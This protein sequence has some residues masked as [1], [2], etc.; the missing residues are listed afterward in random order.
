MSDVIG[1]GV[2]EVAADATGVAAGIDAAKR[3]IGT[4]ADAAKGASDKSAAS[5][6]RYIKKLEQQNAT[7]G[8]SAREVELY[9]LKLRGASEAQLA[10]ADAA[11]KNA[12][13]IKRAQAETADASAKAQ[14]AAERELELRDKLKNGMIAAAAATTAAIAATAAAAYASVNAVADQLAKYKDLSDKIGDSAAAIAALQTA[15]DLSGVSLDSVAGASIRLTSALS[16]TD[17]ESKSV[18]AGISALG[19][20]FAKFKEKSPVE[21]LDAVATA[22]AGF[23]DGAEK[24]A[25]AT[26]IFGKSGAEMIPFLNDLADGGE[27]QLKITDEQIAAADEFTKMQSRLK[28]EIADFTRQVGGTTLP[29]LLELI[30]DFKDAATGASGLDNASVGLA[31]NN[32]VQTFAE[33]GLTVLAHLAD[34]AYATGQAFLWLGNNIGTTAAG[35]AAVARLDMDAAKA[36]RAEQISFNDGFKL[37]L[38][39]ADK[40]GEKFAAM[41]AKADAYKDPR[42][43]GNPGSI[44]DQVSNSRPKINISGLAAPGKGGA[45]DKDTSAQDA[46][47]QL[48]I[49][50]DQI[51]AAGDALASAYGNAEKI[52]QAQKAANLVSDGEYYAAKLGFLRLNSAAQEAALQAEIDRLEREK[53]TGK[54]KL[55]NDKKIAE[56]REKLEKLRADTTTNI[57]VNTIQEAAAVA[58]LARSYD[59]AARA[60]ESYVNTIAR[61]SEREL[62]GIGQGAKARA[63]TDRR[64]QRDDQF[65]G[66]RDTLD[67]QLRAGQIGP[68]DYQKFL[69]IEQDAHDQALAADDAYWSA[70]AEKQ[71]DW[72]LGA[73]EALHDYADSAADAFANSQLVVSNAFRGMEDAMTSFITTGKLDFSSL[74]NSIVADITRIIV[75][76]QIANLAMSMMGDGGGSGDS[77]GGGVS[78]FIGNLFGSLMGAGHALGGPVSKGGLY[79]VNERGPELLS[80]AGQQYLMMGSQGGSVTPNNAIGAGGGSVNQVINFH[81]SGPVDRRTQQQVAAQAAAGAQRALARNS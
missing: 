80:V 8:M 15:S 68:D 78:G 79:P 57:E 10:A 59:D 70:K 5:V 12:E 25:V 52:M 47:A 9:R 74:A 81:S 76:Q 34:A 71:R 13:A 46:K 4:L 77:G 32:S 35:A 58:K 54:D 36:I 16:K 63:K 53:L 22:M 7:I 62:A 38:G 42:I 50:L 39:M 45:K 64:N 2:I 6:D 18:G 65:Q 30:S 66:R 60:A 33:S 20:D 28:S 17:D 14:A 40:V 37:S 11:L 69:K 61:S 43:L 26:A 73:S 23:A 3:S 31:K 72:S 44:A 67:S 51:K 48:A 55:D 1:R 56:T 21:Q 29:I 49:D 27:R 24:T 19:L 75:K 41:R